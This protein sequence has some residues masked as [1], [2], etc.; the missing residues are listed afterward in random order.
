MQKIS[1]IQGG[2]LV[3]I[4]VVSIIWCF[5]VC[6][7]QVMIMK[8]IP[9]PKK[10]TGK[11]Q[12]LTVWA[13]AY[14]FQVFYERELALWEE[15]PIY[16][17]TPLHAYLYLNRYQ[18][19]GK[20]PEELTDFELMRAFTIAGILK[21]Y[22]RFDT[23]LMDKVVQKYGF[24]SVYDPCAGWGERLLYCYFHGIRYFGVDINTKLQDG[25]YR[26]I[27]DFQMIDQN[28]VFADSSCYSC[29]D[30]FDA[31][32]TCPPYGN[33][34]IYSEFGAENLSKQEFLRWWKRVVL[35]C[36]QVQPK[37][38]CFQINQKWL[39]DMKTALESCGFRYVEQFDL[40]LRSGHMTRK[41]GKNTKHEFESM[42][43]FQ[44]I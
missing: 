43:V 5:N 38:F 34:E 25:Y 20:T 30:T 4:I 1:G 8:G 18:Y 31:V 32:I 12:N 13:K 21:G 10:L 17:H 44:Y 15:N 27:S 40:G 23:K 35:Q 6:G 26:M 36:L 39:S 19:L 41:N 22:T 3:I 37:Y 2:R 7:K 9:F 42:L 11:S 24:S 14:Q 16:K 28:V 29:N 33:T